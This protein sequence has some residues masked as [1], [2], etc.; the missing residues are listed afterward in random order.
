MKKV[1]KLLLIALMLFY[2]FNAISQNKFTYQVFN[3]TLNIESNGISKKI[4]FVDSSIIS[5]SMRKLD[6]NEAFKSLVVENLP[7]VKLMITVKDLRDSL[8][9]KGGKLELIVQKKDASITFKN[10]GNQLIKET[11]LNTNNSFTDI[12]DGPKKAFS[13]QQ[14][15]V[16][17]PN[18]GVYGLGEFQDGIINRRGKKI[19][20]VQSN[21][22]DV[23]P[24]IVSTNNYGILW[25]N[26]SKTIFNDDNNGMSFWSEIADE[27]NYYLIA[28][29]NMDG[30]IAGYRKIT[31]DAPMFSKSAFGYWQS[32]ERYTSSD[33]VLNIASEYRKRNIPIDNIVLDWN[34]WGGNQY[35]S[36]M[37]F[38][39]K[40]FP[41]PDSLISTLHDKYNLKFM[42]SIWPCVGPETDIYKEL[43]AN[44]L[45]F[46]GNSFFTAKKAR[47][48]DAFSSTGR[49]IYFKYVIDSL[50]KRGVDALWMDGTEP[51][52]DDSQNPLISEKG[53]KKGGNSVIGSLARYLNAYSLMTT[54]GGYEKQREFSNTKRVFT[55]TRS[56][57]AGQQKYGAVTWSGDNGSNWNTLKNQ[58]ANGID[59]SMAGIPYWTHDIGGFFPGYF[60]GQYP[61]GIQSAAWRE[62]YIRW[63]QFGAFTPIF[64]SHGT[65]TRREIWNFGEPGNEMYE[66]LMDFN[67]LRYRLLPY[68]Y[69]TSWQVHSKGFSF[70]RGLMMDA[71]SD[72]ATYNLNGQYM[73]GTDFLVKPVT[74]EMYNPRLVKLQTLP[75]NFLSTNEGN[76]GLNAEYFNGNRFNTQLGTRIDTSFEFEHNSASISSMKI[77]QKNPFSIRWN[78]FLKV[79]ETGEYILGADAD[80]G[81]KIWIE[82]QLLVNEWFDKPVS[83]SFNKIFLD[84][85]KPYK[86][87][88]EY[89]QNNGGAYF[90]LGYLPPSDLSK[91][92]K[93]IIDTVST[94]LPKGNNWFNF[95]TGKKHLGGNSTSIICPLNRMPL[96]VRSGTILPLA[97]TMQFSTQK[98]NDTL[99]IRIYPGKDGTL[100]LYEDENDSYNYEKGLYSIIKFNW[101]NNKKSLTIHSRKGTFPGIIN[102][103]LFKIVIV[104]ES[105]GNGIYWSKLFDKIVPY[106]G[107]EITVQF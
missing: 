42:I 77:A 3:N 76:T 106:S 21:Q 87:R 104:D 12:D 39:R 13:I 99:E 11:Y 26:Y 29:K 1:S 43:D 35:W 6:H 60:E 17:S 53:I 50:L 18:E 71:P 49:D 88:I 15:F 20:M 23:I 31:G 66:A 85:N 41:N 64:R 25:D 92:K 94:Y 78:G 82:D 103:R 63:F 32:R 8:I 86:V 40:F 70:I 16:L 2:S 62:L 100:E 44:E 9:V 48:Y 45:L 30:V 83:T 90:R 38:D 28:A 46:K 36:G 51:E 34:Y 57:F 72:T 95:W 7:K 68:I 98:S 80:D 47:I 4:S 52:F 93:N 61:T 101:N 107:K 73:F 74:K 89:Y 27:I 55:L 105:K 19:T 102:N 65:G 54:K 84:A 14:N 56:S 75:I 79:P 37:R 33:Q 5:V 59:F 97:D 58:I 91:W 67:H 69:N 24:F 10:R 96:F 22:Q 81:V